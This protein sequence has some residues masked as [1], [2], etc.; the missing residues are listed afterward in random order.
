MFYKLTF[1]MD[2][3]DTAIEEGTNT[4]YAEKTNIDDIEYPN[5][6]KGFFDNIIY[7]NGGKVIQSW[8][9]VKFYYSSRA[10]D[11]ESEYLLNAKRWP[12]IHKKVQQ[13][14]EEAGIEGIQYLPIKLIDVVTNEVNYNYVVINVLNFIEAYDLEK[15]KYKYNE[16]YSVYTFLPHE[17][18]LD[19]KVCSNYDIFRCKKSI[20]S[21]YVSQKIKDLAHDNQW[22]GFEFYP[23]KLN[24]D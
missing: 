2:R 4:I 13:K 12:I 3:I 5:I 22:I 20:L 1:D 15:S 23:Q 18:Y 24:N 19:E 11:L 16:K 8:P 6:K 17:T 21:L 10:S 14:F 9:D 7:T